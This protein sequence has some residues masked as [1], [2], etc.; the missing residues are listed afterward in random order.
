MIEEA[1]KKIVVGKNLSVEEAEKV[2]LEILENKVSGVLI[3]SFLI[4]LKMK[5]EKEEEILGASLVAREKAEKINVREGLL[6]VDTE[7]PVVDTCGTGGSGVEKFNI[8]TAVAFVVSS[9][10]IKVVKH[11]NRAI[12]S[13]SGSA[14]VLEALGI[15]INAS[16]EVMEEA[17]KKLGIGFLYAPLYHKA[18]KSVASIRKEIGVRTIFNIVGPLCNPALPDYQLLGVS[19][20]DLLYKMVRVL[21]RLGLKRAFVVFGDKVKDE[22]SIMGRTEV[23]FLDKRKINKFNI[24][25]SH[26][27][28]KRCKLKDIEAKTVQDSAKIIMDIFDGK[29]GP[30]RDIVLANASCCFYLLGKVANFR[31]GVELASQLI[32][33]GKVKDKYIK[34]RDFLEKNKT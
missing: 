24:F 4:G 12:S 28:L 15:D 25:P 10:N 3:A 2:F 8:S 13:S 6:G 30:C 16:K 22:V 33:S 5:G 29:R 32:D 23:A 7:E 27:G 1:I 14:D 18:F 34:F 21:K 31:E 20:R 17:I 26:F 9:A 11:G 19:G